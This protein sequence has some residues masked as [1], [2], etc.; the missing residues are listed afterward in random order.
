MRL[1]VRASS[2][3]ARLD[4]CPVQSWRSTPDLPVVLVVV[5]G[6]LGVPLAY[7]DV[8]AGVEAL[9]LGPDQLQALQAGTL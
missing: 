3:F 8:D 7:G 1:S 4:G 2:G 6:V 5:Q 9:F